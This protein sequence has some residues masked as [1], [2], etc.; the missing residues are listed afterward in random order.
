MVMSKY[1]GKYCYGNCPKISYTKV[2]DKM[3]CTNS[4]EPDQYVPEEAV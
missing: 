1:S 3:A 2:T 4:A